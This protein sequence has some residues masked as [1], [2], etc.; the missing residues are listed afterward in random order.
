MDMSDNIEPSKTKNMH[1]GIGSIPFAVLFALL[2]GV[3]RHFGSRALEGGCQVAL[4]VSSAVVVFIAMVFYKVE[5]ARIEKAIVANIKTISMAL[6]V[7]LCIG[8]VSG[9]WMVS[10]V[11][12]AM[13]YYGLQILSPGIFLLVACVISALVSIMTGSS[14]TT[15]AT[16]GVALIGIGSVLG[17]NPALSAGAIISGAYFGDKLSPL[18]DTTIVASSINEVP[19]FTHIRYMLITTIPSFSIACVAFFVISLCHHSSNDI[20]TVEFSS[21]L[22]Q[23]FSI[24]PWL[25]VVPLLTVILIVKKVPAIITLILSSLMAIATALIAQPDL[26]ASIGGC[27]GFAGQFKGSMLTLYGNTQIETGNVTL[28]SLVETHGMAGML[29]T[30]F[31]ICCSATFGGTLTGSGLTESFTEMLSQRLSKTPSIVASTVC[32]GIGANMATGDQYL[33][34]I[35][36]SNLFKKL[37][38]DKGLENRLLSRSS[39]DSATVVSVLIPWNSCGMTQSRVLNVPT[40]EYLPYC[41]FNILSPIVSICVA[42]TGYK[43]VSRMAPK[44]NPETK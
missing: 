15:I 2:F 43:I 17:F 9:S 31:L 20:Q 33:S 35:L 37:Y 3:L 25:M 36:M 32:S 6:I 22:Q 27:P 28:N 40:L 16:I 29:N 30:I 41:F 18:S 44:T 39:E 8:A 13:I 10:G 11:V 19:L 5:W 1:W 23:T 42:A 7:L 21:S 26:V 12:P 4:L 24:S 38:H 14:W 34:I